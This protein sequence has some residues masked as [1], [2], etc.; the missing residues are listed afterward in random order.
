MSQSAG[1][2]SALIQSR[3]CAFGSLPNEVAIDSSD[4][5]ICAPVK[6]ELFLTLSTLRSPSG[7]RSGLLFMPLGIK[8]LVQIASQS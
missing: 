5:K 3:N 6:Q 7:H 2:S 1:V 4:V 8:R